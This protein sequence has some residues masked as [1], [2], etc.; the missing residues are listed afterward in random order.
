MHKETPSNAPGHSLTLYPPRIKGGKLKKK[1]KK[2]LNVPSSLLSTWSIDRNGFRV[3][4]I[5]T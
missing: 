5:V 1:K 2:E 3:Y 4:V